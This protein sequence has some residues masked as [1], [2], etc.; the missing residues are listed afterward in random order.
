VVLVITF[1]AAVLGGSFGLFVYG[2]VVLRLVCWF[3][4]GW[5]C[6]CLGCLFWQVVCVV[7][8]VV[9]GGDVVCVWLWCFV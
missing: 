2:G 8:G 4:F 1:N 3:C 6:Y 5:V 7:L 9:W